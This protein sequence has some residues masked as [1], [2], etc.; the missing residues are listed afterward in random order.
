[1][2]AIRDNVILLLVPDMNPDGTTM[3]A[4]WYRHN[5]GKPWEGRLPELWHRYTA[6]TTTATGS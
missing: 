5:V 2:R 4:D 1:M 6:T 3:V